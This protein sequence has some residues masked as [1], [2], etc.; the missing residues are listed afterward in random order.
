MCTLNTWK[1][2]LRPAE[3][4]PQPLFYFSIAEKDDEDGCADVFRWLAKTPMAHTVR[5]LEVWCE[6]VPYLE[7]MSGFVRT[8]TSLQELKL[9]MTNG[10]NYTA[11]GLPGEV[12]SF[13]L[14]FF[15]DMKQQ[16]SHQRLSS[17]V[18]RSGRWRCTSLS[19]C[20]R[21]LRTSYRTCTHHNCSISPFICNCRVGG[22]REFP[23]TPSPTWM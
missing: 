2:L 9:D 14:G 19:D 20:S 16:S 10:D 6:S 5:V 4:F 12:N 1:F 7:A 21:P 11:N 18:R 23:Y 15:S 8:S 3:T 22:S 17:Q 13:I